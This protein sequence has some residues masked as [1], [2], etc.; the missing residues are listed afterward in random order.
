MGFPPD[1][2]KLVAIFVQTLLYGAYVVLFGVTTHLFL[3][4]KLHRSAIRRTM[5]TSSVLLF[6]I[7]T[8]HISVNFTR[9]IK[10]FITYRNASGGPPAFF[11]RLSEFTQ[12]LGST[13]YVAQTLLGDG[14]VIWRCYIVWERNLLIVTLPL[15]LLLGST[16]D[17]LMLSL[18]FRPVV[19][20][21][22]H[23]VT[24]IGIL[25]S[26]IFV[27]ELQQWIISFFSITLATNLIATGLVA[28]RIWYINKKGL[29][30][31]HRK[32]YP[33]MILII[34]SGAVYSAAMLALLILYMADSWF[35]YVVLDAISP[36][37]GLVFSLIMFRILSGITSVS[38]ETHLLR[39]STTTAPTTLTTIATVNDHYLSTY[40][41]AA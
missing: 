35:Q 15:L 31:S 18:T 8:M 33:I 36:I 41:V 19:V 32:L 16:D 13:L 26:F 11:N 2:A 9:I 24:G 12:M 1:E 27:H 5:F 17:Y 6:M 25:Y 4:G 20:S 3:A 7:A 38:G 40:S 34:E 39:T 23:S 37:V 30:F 22:D 29:A 21:F 10:A 14:L 28:Y